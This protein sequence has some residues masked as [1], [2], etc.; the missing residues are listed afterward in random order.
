MC[1]IFK[2]N[3]TRINILKRD[4]GFCCCCTTYIMCYLKLMINW[5]FWYESLGD[6]VYLNIF[7]HIPQLYSLWHFLTQKDIL[8]VWCVFQ[9]RRKHYQRWAAAWLI[10]IHRIHRC[11]NCRFFFIAMIINYYSRSWSWCNA[12]VTV[13]AML[14]IDFEILNN[15]L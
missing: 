2:G 1:S 14:D 13:K 8:W 6:L 11:S 4:A 5:F 7:S 3:H 10:T 9:I 15:I 12:I